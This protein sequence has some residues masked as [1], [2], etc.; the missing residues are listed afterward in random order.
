MRSTKS[1]KHETSRR[2]LLVEKLRSATTLLLHH[3]INVEAPVRAIANN[4]THN[5]Y[6]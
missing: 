6:K 5:T 3:P 1:K 2:V 4:A